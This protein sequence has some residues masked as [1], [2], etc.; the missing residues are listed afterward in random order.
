MVTYN[1]SV[2]NNDSVGC[3]A[4]SRAP[5]DSSTTS[6]QKSFGVSSAPA[7][8]AP[9]PCRS[10]RPACRPDL[11]HRQRRDQN[12]SLCSPAGVHVL[13]RRPVTFRLGRR[14]RSRTTSIGPIRRCWAMAG[15]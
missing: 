1:V 6:W 9:R 4:S 13:Q 11:R 5:G 10:R 12:H 3:S 14:G 8:R 15:R 2:T 7:R